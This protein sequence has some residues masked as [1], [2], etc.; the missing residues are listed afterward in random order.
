MDQPAPDLTFEDPPPVEQNRTGRRMSETIIHL[1]GELPLAVLDR[2][3]W[4]QGA[5]GEDGGPTCLHGAIR[6]CAPV[7][8]DA[9]LIEQVERRLGH[10]PDWNDDKST[11][12]A[13]VREFLAAGIDITADDLADTFGP[14]WRAV[15]SVVRTS[16]ALTPE[17]AERLAA[18]LAAARP[19]AWDASWDASWD[20]AWAAA[21]DAAR[22]PEGATRD[23]AWAAEGATRAA[24]W[25][26]ARVAAWVVVAWDLADDDGPYTTAHRDL[27]IGPWKSVFGLPDGLIEAVAS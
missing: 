8:G 26:A 5:W 19:A 12:E 16:A 17:Q 22:D 24:A 1:D 13:D 4:T 6:R 20:A 27:L 10:G 11:T 23:A 18:A 9:Y 25:D 21:W 14:Q 2:D 3:G 7:P 15:V